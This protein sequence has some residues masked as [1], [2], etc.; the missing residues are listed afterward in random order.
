M[1]KKDRIGGYSMIAIVWLFWFI[2]NVFNVVIL[3]NFLIAF[4]SETYEEV[5][6]RDLI[7]DF[8]NKAQLNFEARQIFNVIA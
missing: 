3:L 2:M 8:S 6:D 4:I 7:D 1:E 5:Y